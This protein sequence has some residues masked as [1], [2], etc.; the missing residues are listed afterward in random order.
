MKTSVRFSK[1]AMFLF[2]RGNISNYIVCSWP[3]SRIYLVWVKL[4][5][6]TGSKWGNHLRCSLCHSSYVPAYEVPQG[7][8]YFLQIACPP[9]VPSLGNKPNQMN[10]GKPRT[11][12]I[13]LCVNYCSPDGNS[14]LILM[15]SSLYL[16]WML[17]LHFQDLC[18]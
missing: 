12:Y 2:G 9:T 17:L 16:C 8:G 13:F 18:L 15:F 7:S 6:R 10:S 5:E 11:M 14:S 1:D 4:K 3:Y